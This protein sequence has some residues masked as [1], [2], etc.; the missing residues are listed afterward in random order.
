[1]AI[2][3]HI[4]DT[5]LSEIHS[6]NRSFDGL[7]NLDDMPCILAP[8]SQRTIVDPRLDSFHR[9]DVVT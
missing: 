2:D 5:C 4:Q 6:T 3:R 7:L 8:A 1:M 9:S